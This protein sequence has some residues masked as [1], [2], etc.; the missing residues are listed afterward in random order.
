M[1]TAEREILFRI[2]AALSSQF[3]SAMQAA[4]NQINNMN[5]QQRLSRI[6]YSDAMRALQKY[7]GT[8]NETAAN[9]AKFKNLNQAIGQ[10]SA[11][12]MQARLDSARL[13]QE[14][15]QQRQQTD[16]M[17]QS[18]DRLK[19]VYR[20]ERGSMT[21]EQRAVWQSQIQAAGREL[22][23]QRQRERAALTASTG[24]NAEVSRLE[25]Q[26]TQ[27]RQK[28]TEL[29]NSLSTAGVNVA[30][31][32]QE[33][34]RLQREI[35]ETTNALSRQEEALLRR[36]AV[37]DRHQ[38]ASE[39][40]SAARDNFQ[41]AM[42]TAQSI[43]SPFTDAV[44]VS[45]NFNKAMSEVQAITNATGTEFDALKAKAKEL[46]AS[47]MFSASDVASG[48]IELGKSGF[49]PEQINAS[50]ASNLNLAAAGSTDLGTSSKILSDALT[51]FKVDSKDYAK[52]S[53]HFADV[54]AKT[55]NSSN[56]SVE[57]LGETFKYAGAVAGS[58]GYSFNDVAV[59]AGLM[60][61][62]G[63]NGSMAG[64]ALRS[65]FTRLISP[66]KD[67]A[68][69]LEKLGVSA[70]TADGK[71]KP[72]RETLTNLRESF[73][74]LSQAE[75]AEYATQIA[76][77]EAQAGF[78]AMVDADN[79]TFRQMLQDIDNSQGAAAQTAA[80]K[81][82]NLA[83]AVTTFQSAFE[84][85]QIA[86]G[87]AFEDPLKNLVNSAAENLGAFTQWVAKHQELAQA[88]GVAA[89]AISGVIVA[90]A[91]YSVVST[92]VEYLAASYQH[93]KMR[94]LESAAAM[95]ASATASSWSAIGA[96]ISGAF[97]SLTAKIAAARTAVMSFFATA[98]ATNGASIITSITNIGSAFLTAAKGA[99]AFAFSPVGVALMA[100]AAAG[101]YVYTHW[102]QVAPVFQNLASTLGGSLQGAITTI[103]AAFES[104]GSS[105][106]RLG[107]AFAQ[108]GRYA[109][110]A[111]ALVANVVVRVAALIITSFANAIK[112]VV[113]LFSGLGNA[114]A[115]F[116]A[117]DF[118]KAGEHL[119]STLAKTF[120]NVKKTFSDGFKGAAD[121]GNNFTKPIEIIHRQEAV[122]A[123][124]A[125]ETQQLNSNIV[126]ALSTAIESA[127]K[128]N[129]DADLSKISD[130]IKATV[131]AVKQDPKT[132]LTPLLQQVSTAIESVKK[133]NPEADTSKLESV[134]SSAMQQ[135]SAAQKEKSDSAEMVQAV[136][137]A[138]ESLKQENSEADFSKIEAAISAAVEKSDST[139]NLAAAISTA[140]ESTKQEQ[141][142]LDLTPI[143]EA[144][145]AAQTQQAEQKALET[146][147]SQQNINNLGQAA[148]DTGV[149]FTNAQAG[150]DMLT[151]ALPQPV[152]GL[153]TL[154]DSSSSAASGLQGMA[155]AAGAVASALSAKAAEI[156]S[157]HISAPTISAT[158]AAA[159]YAGGI[160]SKG[161]FLTTF[162]EKSPEAAIP[163][164]NSKRAIDLWTKTGQM[165]GQLPGK[166]FATQQPLTSER[167]TTI[168]RE[169]RQRVEKVQ[170]QYEAAKKRV[171][172]PNQLPKIALPDSTDI[173]SPKTFPTAPPKVYV[174]QSNL[175]RRRNIPDWV[176]G[177]STFPQT[178]STDIELPRSVFSGRI[179]TPKIPMT[180]TLPQ[181]YDSGI[182]LGDIFG[183]ISDGGGILSS[184]TERISP[185][186]EG[187][188]PTL[189]NNL[190]QSEST[191]PID[192]HFEINIA[193]N[194]NA[195]DVEQGIRQTIPLIEETLEQ[196]IAN[197]R[198]EEQRRSF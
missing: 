86:I 45:M 60:A 51:M 28:L 56:T 24:K 158:P 145:A 121:I 81:T 173:E 179:E 169:Q 43:M 49:N 91:G 155:D 15:N 111:F 42:S 170:S 7:Q 44:K 65:T 108:I 167:I 103:M 73:S 196:K 175:P 33:E 85:L 151:S 47:T 67:A 53:E 123:R 143:T 185:S 117:G 114:I 157:I 3:A 23:E 102:S 130:A 127:Q 31:L 71:V 152:G 150:A 105:T 79:E 156:S 148:A 187:I 165:L 6:E 92:G 21:A 40:F 154:G 139:E 191:L 115:S 138:I 166:S 84:G 83:G 69:A 136:S 48:M 11:A 137:T 128:Q 132:D 64:T 160:Y 186:S 197:L 101:Y 124:Q 14:Y 74:K 41:N 58:L 99:M 13:R 113:E 2:N 176:K 168:E 82:D 59:A 126:T 171:T 129:S 93:L 16:R 38:A 72:F 39:K 88:A 118:S 195:E 32:A 18:F 164:D 163:I 63:L 25:T 61:K 68:A 29:R 180:Q 104:L 37:Q 4:Q 62:V 80:Q 107:P 76:G 52:E 70:V 46:G 34:E 75:K 87:D 188:I 95:R 140:I 183:A 141:P 184:I 20:N 131:D 5:R 161:A 10:N 146:E 133:E 147:T 112:T 159:N 57:L 19:E 193:G 89:A 50:I 100:L 35:E 190:P 30:Q 192:L 162:A 17:K 106:S 98:A 144:I 12:L 149:S 96:G 22:A 8:L 27:Q 9:V 189:M 54:M 97:T 153:Q 177:N 110:M 122:E 1:A 142:E 134:L 66:P 182:N 109:F 26:L 178:D 55:A 120:E 174:S 119:S 36:Q 78:L 116:L 94:V 198:H 172:V 135:I 77:L 90:V 181:N 125:Q 194:A